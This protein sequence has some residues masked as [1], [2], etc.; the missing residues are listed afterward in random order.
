MQIHTTPDGLEITD[1]SLVVCC[2]DD[3]DGEPGYI[4]LQDD[5]LL[6]VHPKN[7]RKMIAMLETLED[8]LKHPLEREANNE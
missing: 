1:G 2:N 6:G 5:D 7:I 8:R 3:D 4:T